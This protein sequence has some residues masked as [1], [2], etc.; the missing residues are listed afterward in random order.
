METQFREALEHAKNMVLPNYTE[1]N[2]VLS[3]QYEMVERQV[4]D[5]LRINDLD[6]VE[7]VVKNYARGLDLMLLKS[8]KDKTV[9]NWNVWLVVGKYNDGVLRTAS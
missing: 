1:I 7:L 5:F 3:G 6:I 9:D 4:D 2:K 8:S